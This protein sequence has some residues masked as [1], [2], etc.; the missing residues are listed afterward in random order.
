ME[1]NRADGKKCY[2]IIV[3]EGGIQQLSDEDLEGRRRE[4]EEQPKRS[5]SDEE[6]CLYL[7]FPRDAV[8]FFRLEE[9]Y[10]KT[11]LLPPEV[12]LWR[13]GFEDGHRITFPD[14]GGNTHRIDS[15]STRR[16]GDFAHTSLLVDHHFQTHVTAVRPEGSPRVRRLWTRQQRMQWTLRSTAS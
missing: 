11:W 16:A 14:Y 13:G 3:D 5:A 15:I 9:Q 12:W 8:D 1:S 2:R 7:Q 6:L 4:L 10:G